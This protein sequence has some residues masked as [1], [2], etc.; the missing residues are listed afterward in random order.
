MRDR[1]NVKVR[2][3]LP[4]AEI[5]VNIVMLIFM[6]VWCRAFLIIPFL[7]FYN[8]LLKIDAATGANQAIALSI[9][10]EYPLKIL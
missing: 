4:I 9:T 3:Y 8:I 5:P 1:K 6:G 2:I 10:G 7:I